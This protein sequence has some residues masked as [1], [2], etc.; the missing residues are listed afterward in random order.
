MKKLRFQETTDV[1]GSFQ[2]IGSI[3][4]DPP[5]TPRW[6]LV[7]T[8]L[9]PNQ[10]GIIQVRIRG[11]LRHKSNVGGFNQIVEFPALSAVDNSDYTESHEP[12]T[13]DKSWPRFDEYSIV[14]RRVSGSGTKS[15]SFFASTLLE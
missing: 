3:T 12:G 4:Y 15:V 9:D 11:R 5:Q 1:Q 13:W 10:N 14:A 8:Q 6:L 7:Q 2:E